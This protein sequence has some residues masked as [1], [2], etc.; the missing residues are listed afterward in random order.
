VIGRRSP[1]TRGTGMSHAERRAFAAALDKPG[2]KLTA[3]EKVLLVRYET[4]PRQVRRWS[5]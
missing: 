2:G 3:A 1:S 5:R 4:A